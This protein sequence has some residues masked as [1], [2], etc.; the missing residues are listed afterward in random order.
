MVRQETGPST[1]RVTRSATPFGCFCS[2]TAALDKQQP[3]D[4]P[5]RPLALP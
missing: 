4:R 3:K 5:P 1:A 2:R